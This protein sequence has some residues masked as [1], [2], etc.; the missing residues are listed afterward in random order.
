MKFPLIWLKTKKRRNEHFGDK[1]VAKSRFLGLFWDVYIENELCFSGRN[2]EQLLQN[3]YIK[4]ASLDRYYF[5]TIGQ[6][7][8]FNELHEI[9]EYLGLVYDDW[10]DDD[11]WLFNSE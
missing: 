9:A 10:G 4:I 3:T 8:F 6:S 11:D 1:V 7:Y 2:L 5:E